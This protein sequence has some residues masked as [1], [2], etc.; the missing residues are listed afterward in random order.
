MTQETRLDSI[1][2]GFAFLI[3]ICA[4]IVTAIIG[5]IGVLWM[6]AAA[7][8]GRWQGVLALFIF[9]ALAAAQGWLVWTAPKRRDA[10]KAGLGTLLLL[11]SIVPTL[12]LI[13]VVTL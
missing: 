8:D 5:S 2:Y 1:T 3:A 13:L 11:I 4:L 10:G 12:V 9:S 7:F 6:A